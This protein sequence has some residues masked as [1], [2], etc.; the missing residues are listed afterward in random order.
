VSIDEGPV[1]SSKLLQFSSRKPL[2]GND[3]PLKVD[4][5]NVLNRQYVSC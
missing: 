1:S 5:E 2:T 4:V 3:R